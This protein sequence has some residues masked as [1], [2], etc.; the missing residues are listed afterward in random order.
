MTELTAPL[1]DKTESNMTMAA[2]VVTN[3]DVFDMQGAA[4]GG[5]PYGFWKNHTALG[6]S[7]TVYTKARI[8][9]KVTGA[10]AAAQFRLDWNGGGH[11]DLLLGGS[12]Q[13]WT[14]FDV[15]LTA[16]QTIDYVEMWLTT[17]SGHLYVDFVML[18]KADFTIPNTVHG[19]N[20][21]PYARYVRP[22]P[23]G[24][25]GAETENLGSELAEVI[26]HSDLDIGNWK[27]AGDVL[28]GQV[29]VDIAHNSKTE[30][31]Q[32]LTLG[33]LQAKFKVT[34]DKPDFQAQS[35]EATAAK[36][37]MLTMYEY[38]RGPANDETYA[39]RYGL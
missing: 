24:M 2:I 34:L 1:W 3:D 11:Q 35:A 12:A 7:S 33:D 20:F 6:L 18:Y 10:G 27:R 14:T 4:T 22:V 23:P 19:M 32:W 39:E 30:D 29:F 25:A 13:T 9:Y 28:P 21:R 38:R 17:A 36:T 31:F 16:G 5:G 15:D 26:M 37:L 8:R